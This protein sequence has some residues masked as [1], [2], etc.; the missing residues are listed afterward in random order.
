MED[1]GVEVLITGA[2]DSPLYFTAANPEASHLEQFLDHWKP[3]A[4]IWLGGEKLDPA[5]VVAVQSRGIANFIVEAS[6][7]DLNQTMAKWYPGMPR[8]LMANVTYALCSDAQAQKRLIKAK[9]PANNV[10]ITGTI[11]D[12]PEVLD[13][14]E[15]QF[16]DIN[17]A[18]GTRQSWLAAPVRLAEVS[19]LIEAHK[20]ACRR[21]HRLLLIIIPAL[22]ED[23]ATIADGFREHGFET[24]LS[25]HGSEITET[26]RVLVHDGDASNLGLWYR[27]S[28]ITYAAG[29]LIGGNPQ[30]PFD[31]ATLGSSIIHGPIVGAFSHRYSRLDQAGG[32]LVINGPSDLGT[33]VETL[34]SPDRTATIAMAAWDV[35]SGGAIATTRVAA[36]IKDELE[37]KGY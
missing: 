21:A 6:G 17:Q 27:I 20:H 11:D 28:P 33:A 31:I 36:L 16:A 24:L 18:I 29:T 3:D 25:K 2:G 4:V 8:A 15:D 12:D 30:D 14:D 32:C 34:L 19:L 22:A 13:F 5:S 7:T 23:A 9:I 1:L 37:R 35:T 10:E 26:T